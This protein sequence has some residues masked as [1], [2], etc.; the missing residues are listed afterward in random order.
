M[1]C[2]VCGVDCGLTHQCSGVAAEVAPEEAAP[3]PTGF[4]PGYYLTLAFNIARLDGVAIRR[5]ARDSNATYYGAAVWLLTACVILVVRLFAKAVALA[6]TSG[7]ALLITVVV[8]MSVG[9]VLMAVAT[10]LQLGLCHVL[11]K[12]LFGASGTYLEVMRPLLLGWCVN[13][14][15]LI[16]VIGPIV[17]GLAWMILL[18]IVFE[19]ADGIERLQA[20]S[21]S[22]G[23]SGA[24]LLLQLLLS[25][26]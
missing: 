17:A 14:L 16:P 6:G 9:L 15:I 22:V 5:A 10:F 1:R 8:G 23:I 4:A 24:A 7:P 18:M 2:D 11:A 12:W 26:H 20:L 21:I 25:S 13:G 3:P 19:E